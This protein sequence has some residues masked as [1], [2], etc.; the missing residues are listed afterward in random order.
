MLEK[1]SNV[2]SVSEVYNVSRGL[3][4]KLSK[5]NLFLLITIGYSWLTLAII[6]SYKLTPEDRFTEILGNS[7]T[8][9]SIV[10]GL[11]A[12]M[13]SFISG[14][15]LNRSLGQINEASNSVNKSRDHISNFIGEIREISESSAANANNLMAAHQEIVDS[16][17][18]M[19]S[20]VD[21]FEAKFDDLG[22]VITQLPNRLDA[23]KKFE[24]KF[25]DLENLISQLPRQLDSLKD[26]EKRMHAFEYQRQY[27]NWEAAKEKIEDHIIESFEQSRLEGRPTTVDCL[28]VALHV[29]WSKLKDCIIKY[30]DDYKEYPPSV[31]RLKA[32]NKTWKGWEEDA[33][34]WSPQDNSRWKKYN[35][36]FWKEVYDFAQ[37]VHN[38]KYLRIQVLAY[39]YD[40]NL[41]G[42]LINNR[43]LYRS[44]CNFRK[45]E[46]TQNSR[47]V[48]HDSPYF[49]YLSESS[50]FADN[51]ISDF[52]YWF[53]YKAQIIL[54]S[55]V[56]A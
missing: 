43:H 29:S 26:I 37:E 54:D 19:K 8:A 40:P 9:I 51:Q 1:H 17:N 53:D 18:K 22:N 25:D 55:Y 56:K 45:D 21:L 16:Q 10:L 7:A 33:E 36:D 31:I 11:V 3:F 30:Y 48:V 6:F 28:G 47:L 44:S 49:Y 14:E 38:N 2:N 23:L 12:I 46:L 24:T 50:K 13:Y 42:V 20:A 35:N 52:K 4:R 41:H 32:L 27:M 15:S 39:D 34:R 5:L